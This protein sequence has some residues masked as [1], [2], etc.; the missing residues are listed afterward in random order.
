MTC[1]GDRFFYS[2]PQLLQGLGLIGE[3]DA[4]FLPFVA[5]IEKKGVIPQAL[6]FPLC[7]VLPQFDLQPY[8]QEMVV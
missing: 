3:C 8:N 7:P 6:V 1:R 5:I 4:E 2:I